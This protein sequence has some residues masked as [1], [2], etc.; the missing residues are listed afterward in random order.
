MAEPTGDSEAASGIDA[1]V[2]LVCGVQSFMSCS[3]EARHELALRQ[4]IGG[5]LL[6]LEVVDA[7]RIEWM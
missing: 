2:S 7:G 5:V 3:Y 1:L 4:R 6:A